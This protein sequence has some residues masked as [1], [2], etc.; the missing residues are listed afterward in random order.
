MNWKSHERNPIVRMYVVTKKGKWASIF[1]FT[2]ALFHANA[3][4]N[5]KCVFGCDVHKRFWYHTD[6][7][8]YVNPSGLSGWLCTVLESEQN[9]G[10]TMAKWHILILFIDLTKSYFQ[11][12]LSSPLCLENSCWFYFKRGHKNILTH[13]VTLYVKRWPIPC[14]SSSNQFVFVAA[15]VVVN[16]SE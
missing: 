2:G 11:V 13:C 10:P 5:A 12:I 6:S 15:R 4:A 16:G 1:D 9:T 7:D 8:R 14:G 3:N